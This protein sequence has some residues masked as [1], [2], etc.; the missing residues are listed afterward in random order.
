MSETKHPKQIRQEERIK[1]LCEKYHDTHLTFNTP[2]FDPRCLFCGQWPNQQLHGTRYFMI[3]I[4]DASINGR[5]RG[6]EWSPNKICNI[7]L[8]TLKEYIINNRFKIDFKFEKEIIDNIDILLISDK[9][10]SVV[11]VM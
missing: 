10:Q 11:K 6:L 3:W 9:K 8:E 1:T 5:D 2:A 7:C 4:Q